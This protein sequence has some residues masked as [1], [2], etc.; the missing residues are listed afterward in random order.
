[1]DSVQTL[2]RRDRRSVLPDGVDWI[3]MTASE[4]LNNDA[5]AGISSR[6]PRRVG[7]CQ[8]LPPLSRKRSP[9]DALSRTSYQQEVVGA[10]IKLAMSSSK[11]H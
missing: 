6:L 7:I 3:F 11:C 5:S 10:E 2:R 1:M 9:E 8:S 4:T